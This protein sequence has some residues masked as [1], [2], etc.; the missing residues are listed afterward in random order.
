MRSTLITT[1]AALLGAEAILANPITFVPR[2]SKGGA[3]SL[4]KNGLSIPLS[5]NNSLD[6]AATNYT[7][8]WAG[9]VL[10][11]SGF[12]SVVGTFTVPTPKI[13][14]GGTP[15]TRYEG[16]AW[17]GLDGSTCRTAILQTGINWSVQGDSVSFEP[18]YEWWPDTAHIF[19]G[20]EVR[21][22]DQIKLTATA[23][24]TSAGSVL[25]QNLS[26]GKEVSQSFS[27][28]SDLLCE[29][30]AE[31]IVEDFKRGGNSV[32]FADFRSVTFT[33]ASATTSEGTVGLSGATIM[34]IRQDNK[35]LTSS[36]ISGS[37][38]VTVSY[39]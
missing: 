1:L 15:D 32:P 26:T 19:S 38:S 25:I 4:R 23:S 37:S 2:S 33:G 14:P 36:S 17:V 10:V 30:N 3:A 12:Q 24:S 39:L 7:A 9:A 6:S 20:F 27:G 11:G 21:G 5:D 22:G 35:V 18:W 29:T 34:D 31:W 28:E 16:S 13:P 8:N